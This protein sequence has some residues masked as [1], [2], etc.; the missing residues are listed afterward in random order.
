MDTTIKNLT[1]VLTAI[2]NAEN[3]TYELIR[4]YTGPLPDDFIDQYNKIQQKLKRATAE[5]DLN[6]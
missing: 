3:D 5:I 2:K 4:D 1:E 6:Q